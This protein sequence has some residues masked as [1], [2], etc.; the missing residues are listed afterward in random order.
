MDEKLNII[1]LG[2]LLHDIGKIVRRAGE[3]NLKHQEAGAKY[4]E[5]NKLLLDDY[6]E[7]YDI[8]K[9]HHAKELQTANLSENSLAY[10]V[11][12]ADNI[13]S[14]IDR[15]KYDEDV[16]FGN[17]MLPLNSIFNRVKIDKISK[18]KNFSL[19]DIT[20][21]E[22]IF[23]M[24]KD[25]KENEKLEKTD[26]LRILNKLKENIKDMKESFIPERLMTVLEENCIYFPSSAY[27]DYPD[28]SYYDHVKLTAAVAS[29]LYLYDKENNIE[30]YKQE[31]FGNKE[32]RNKEKFLFVSGEFSGIQNF[33]YTITSKMAMKSL[34]GRSF[35]LELFIEHIIDEILSA[36]KLSRVNLIYSGGSQFYLLLPNI[37]KSKEILR[38]YKEKINDFL[39][40]EVGSGIYYEMSFIPVSAE[41]LGNGLSKKIKDENKIGEI[42]RKTSI[43]TSKSK[44]NRYSVRQLEEIFD[45]NSEINKIHDSTKECKICKKS[46]KENILVYNSKHNSGNIEI[47]NACKNYIELGKN[48]SKL[49]H[50]E[51]DIFI[52]E[53]DIFM[54]EKE[55][56]IVKKNTE[57]SIDSLIFPK[58][59][60]GYVNIEFLKRKEVE[61]ELK[62][63]N[64]Y[65]FY[66]V[67]SYYS[68]NGLPKNIKIGNYNIKSEKKDEDKENNSQGLIEFTELVKKA[69][70]IERLAVF[71]ADVDNLGAL[72]QSG[73]IDNSSTDNKYKYVTL[74]KSVVLSR[75]LSD[76]FKR[77]I[78]LILE[79]KNAAKEMNEYFKKYCDV[80]NNNNNEHRNIVVVYSGGDD[81]F[82]I[83]TWNDII[84][85]SVDL[86]TAFKEFTNGKITMSA[87]IGFFSENFPVY[88]MAE[89]TGE[90]EKIA[91]SYSK[92][93][94]EVP[95]KDAVALF[96]VINDK[97]NHVYDWNTFID[98]VLNE[99]YAYLK[100]AVT[101]EENNNSDKLFV[102]KS[103]WYSLMNLIE[104]RLKDENNRIDI[105]RFAYTLAR[106]KNDSKNKENYLKFKEKL[107][108]WIKN[109][110][111]AKQLLTA[112]NIIIYEERGN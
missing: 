33:I 27:M 91:K 8:I 28:I 45:E 107:F 5:D 44:L 108:N 68:G 64:I 95:T 1:Q 50:S 40:K 20:S 70:G 109:E 67:N 85:F 96:G 99:K 105:A 15:V 60:D 57:K 71:R 83:G 3:S 101:F 39:L 53:K 47:C 22:E 69:K 10:I 73:F 90:L 80:I 88:Q 19:A 72:F 61:K 21:K 112:I 2:A 66:A 25:K 55:M 89:R 93:N 62:E 104:S 56:A 32:L 46:E 7:I 6:K 51:K 16:S 41:E 111:D 43:L 35:Y 110:K 74:S 100:S 58:Y 49:Y 37:Q 82:A 31:Y 79:K 29:C 77:K 48:I 86:R 92:E 75:Y 98:K 65:R 103:K 63:E 97:L 38:N 34:R 11:Y 4:L 17:E 81:I 94:S 78:N 18:E 23:N 52:V 76:F 24:P 102:G 106:I 30:N 13:S 42:F 14:G 12:E 36:L 54:T 9:Y 26:Y 84:E 59:I 87:G